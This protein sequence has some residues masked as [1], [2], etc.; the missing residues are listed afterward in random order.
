MIKNII[1]DLGNVTFHFNCFDMIREITNS[2][3]EYEELKN[4]TFASETWKKY[5]QGLYTKEEVTDIF[6]SQVEEDYKKDKLRDIMNRW[7]DYVV[8][9]DRIINLI[10]TWRENGYQTFILSNAPYEIPD[11]V[12]A[13]GLNEIFDGSVF[14]CFEHINKPDSRLYQI[15]LEKYDLEAEECAFLDDRHDNCDT[16]N[17]LGIFGICYRDYAY[18]EAFENLRKL[19]VKF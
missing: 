17:S 16:A 8:N 3:E 6:L 1:F 13:R 14:S 7:T 2:D 9:N 4:I 10:K 19:G 11:M 12:N 18:E 5:D 15:L